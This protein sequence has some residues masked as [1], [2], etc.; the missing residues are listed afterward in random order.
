MRPFVVVALSLLT[1]SACQDGQGPLAPDAPSPR[2]SAS[3][4]S[5]RY[6]VVFEP[7]TRDVPGQAARLAAAHGSAPEFVY[8]HALAGFA[9]PLS[10][11]AVEA[12]RRHPGVAYVVQDRPVQAI[13]QTLPKGIDRVDADRSTVARIDGVD[14]RVDVDV[15]I[16][17][18]G[19][20]LGHPDLNVV[21]GKNCIDSKQA[22]GD[23]HGH[24]T[25]VAGTVGA[26]DNGRDVVG[27]APGARVHAVKVLS[28]N[29]S[30]SWATV[31][32]GI[33][34]VTA[35]AGTIEVAN[36]SLGG[37]RGSSSAEDPLRTALA[38]SV[39]AGVFYAV[40]A[41]NDGADVYGKDGVF[42][43]GD[44]YVPA[45][46]P[47]VATVSAMADFDGTHGGAAGRSLF[48]GCGWLYD[49]AI[50]D[51][52]S[53]FSAS[54]VASNPV[55]S[56]GRAI[57]VAA[58]GVSVLSTKTGGG[59]TAMTGT[60]MA[61]P[62]VAGVAALYVAA[63]GRA[64]NAAGVH[65][66]RQALIDGGQPQ[67]QWQS[68]STRD[69]DGNREP[70]VYALFGSSGGSTASTLHVGDLDGSANVK[71]KSGKWEAQVRVSVHDPS[72][73]PVANATVHGTWSGGAS[74]TVSG[75]TGSDGTVVLLSGNIGS[76]TSATFTIDRIEHTAASY[77]AA[78]N[79]DPDGDSNG[80][81]IV[82]NR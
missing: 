44:D 48:I 8:E 69:P 40:A 23:G 49:D 58:P 18:T 75:V 4:V 79:H 37:Q 22:P 74:G 78:S 14:E 80:T 12:L 55:N 3:G 20:D 82:V 35:N 81:T 30:G 42:G 1:L 17:D 43:T 73:Q 7:G 47:E 27:V 2:A 66:V 13:G 6:I 62:H 32:C 36:M 61:S 77:D 59:T 70:M 51:C 76:G 53:N 21:A 52:F 24:G 19:I 34:W 29:G 16:L 45:S 11:A 50:A 63:H 15:A 71:G 28:D 25:H 64:G 67:S 10:A 68:G 60:S 56:P 54:V 38:N 65:A 9:A 31:I 33:D 46:Y 41:G 57:D 72:H 39:G 26:L 5:D